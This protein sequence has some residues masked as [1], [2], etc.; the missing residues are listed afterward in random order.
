MCMPGVFHA[1][2]RDNAA[3]VASVTVGFISLS[4]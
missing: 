3:W 4:N 2:E 1:T